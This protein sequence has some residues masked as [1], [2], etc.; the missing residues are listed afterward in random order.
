[1]EQL[2]DLCHGVEKKLCCEVISLKPNLELVVSDLF[3]GRGFHK[4]FL[5][6]QF[7]KNTRLSLQFIK[8]MVK[9]S[10]DFGVRRTM[11]SVGFTTQ[12]SYSASKVVKR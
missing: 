12:R 5:S 11:A 6:H 10:V 2:A 4:M 8:Y 9:M 3:E 1:M 7:I